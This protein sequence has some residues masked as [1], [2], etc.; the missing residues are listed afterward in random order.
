M[1][2]LADCN[3]FYASCEKA[4]RP[5]LANK[6]V[7]V[8]S[9]NDGC[10][11]A[12]CKYAKALGIV[13]GTPFFKVKELCKQHGVVA[14]SSNYELYGDMSARVME[15]LA[16]LVPKVEIYSI[17]EAFLDLDGLV[18]VDLPDFA[19]YVRET[20]TR[21]TGIP[22]SIGAGA[23]KTLAKAANR[24]AKRHTDDFAWAVDSE[25]ERERLLRSMDTDDIWGI[26]HRL[27]AH[28]KNMNVDTAWEFSNCPSA[29][30]RKR[31]GVTVQRVLWELQGT[32]CLGLQVEKPK[33]EIICSRA[34]GRIVFQSWQL[35]QAIARYVTRAAEKLRAQDGYA[36]HIRIFLE[37]SNRFKDDRNYWYETTVGLARPTS[38]T[39]EM[40]SACVSAAYRLF[41]SLPH[42]PDPTNVKTG[43]RKAGVILTD[44]TWAGEVQQELFVPQ[45]SDKSRKL[46]KA[47]DSI[48]QR[49]GRETV[50]MAAQGIQTQWKMRRELK[51]PNFTTRL[52]DIPS[53]FCRNDQIDGKRK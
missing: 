20:V 51:S 26:G 49:Y 41:S 15:T 39:G 50:Y 35:E 8:L 14:F 17:D 16:A 9:N 32:R 40:I 43:V 11:I 33:K 5:D 31:F 30:I 53:V 19:R 52:A 27:Q 34:F 21:N 22:V 38:N 4:F 42:K 12:L 45:V 25:Q 23:T 10:V 29:M 37:G 1:Y 44:I 7:V 36:Q 2:A 48:N 18:G 13:M 24:Y 46:M 6:P 3:T 47:F 28:L